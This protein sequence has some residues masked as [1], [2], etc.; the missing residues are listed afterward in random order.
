M[1]YEEKSPARIVRLFFLPHI[2]T[3]KALSANIFSSRPRCRSCK[4]LSHFCSKNT[5]KFEAR[6][7]P[8]SGILGVHFTRAKT[9]SKQQSRFRSWK[10]GSNVKFR[11]NTA[12]TQRVTGESEIRWRA[13]A[14]K[15]RSLLGGKRAL[16][17]ASAEKAPTGLG[18]AS[19]RILTKVE[20]N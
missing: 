17:R 16:F 4:R 10:N 9:R 15:M 7:R 13:R 11:S 12:K 14:R 8:Q 5:S 6:I 3:K 20:Q 19:R 1:F 18:E 2:A